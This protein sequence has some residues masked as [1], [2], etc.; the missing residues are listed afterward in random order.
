[1]I[2]LVNDANILIDLLK[3]GLLSP[4]F[5]LAYDFQVADMVLAEIQEDNAVALQSFL[6]DG[7]VT[8]QEFSF[9]ELKEIQLLEIEN[10]SLSI[11]DCS[12][13]YLCQKNSATLLTGDAALRRVAEQKAIPVHGILWCFDEMVAGGVIPPE[14]AGEKLRQLMALNPRL[15]ERECRKRLRAY[16]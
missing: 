1:M 5:R 3:I 16:S 13:L 6:A 9:A 4:F 2:L 15:P 7:L 8:R 10:P 14:K 11:P 12:C